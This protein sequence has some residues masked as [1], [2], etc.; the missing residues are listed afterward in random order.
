M[1][2]LAGSPPT[3]DSVVLVP[4]GGTRG[5]ASRRRAPAAERPTLRLV[6]FG[7]LGLYGTIRWGSLLQ[8][9]PVWRLLGLLALS[10]TLVALADRLR[11]YRRPALIALAVAAALVVLPLS[12]IPVR[13]ITHARVTV[14]AN[15]LGDGLSALPRALVPYDGIN[16]WLRMVIVLG[17]GVLLLDG[18]LM[19][20][21]APRPLS[22]LRRAAA[23]LPLMALAAVPSTLVRPSLPYLQGLILFVL[24]AAFMWG[25]RLRGGETMMAVVLASVAGAAGM[26]AAPRLD[27]GTPWLDYQALAGDLAPAHPEAFDWRQ[28]Y[29]PLHW[30][31]TGR[32]VLDVQAQHPDYWKAENLDVF[33]GR[34]WV[35]AS[36]GAPDPQYTVDPA[37]VSRWTQKLHVTLRAM[38]TTN[39]IAAGVAETPQHAPGTLVAGSSQGTWIYPGEL[40]PGYSYTVSS[41]D[42]HPSST[43]L[44]GAGIDYPAVLLPAYLT[45]AIP[46]DPSPPQTGAS[47]SRFR[48]SSPPATIIFAPFG[49]T[50]ATAYGP[51]T[52]QQLGLLRRS[53]YGPV[54]ALSQRLRRG[55]ATP[56][57]YVTRVERYLQRG[58]RY[59]EGPPPSAY[60]LPTFLFKTRAGYCQQFAGAMALLLRMGGIPARV[61]AG[62]TPGSYDSAGHQWVVSD[63]NAHAWVEAWFPRYG[64]VRFDPTP[65]AA[66]ALG[67]H[68]PLPTIKNPGTGSSGPTNP[69]A[70]GLGPTGPAPK[71]AGQGGGG[72]G[73]IPLIIGLVV[74]L[75]VA[76]VAGRM[77]I[78]MREPTDEQLLAELERAL[79]RCGRPIGPRTTL[80]ALEQRF[81]TS[82]EAAGYI[83]ALRL[84]RFAG[85][86][87]PPPETGRRALRAQLRAGLGP[88]GFVRALWALPPQVRV[89][90]LVSKPPPAGIH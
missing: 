64:W 79:R 69:S 89:W 16:G 62:F 33:D 41:Y 50:I 31:R 45:L 15:A 17:A 74:L 23:A 4:A 7:A 75:V 12:G 86:S 13:W 20:A 54:Y 42:P 30:P 34:A 39:V 3:A 37:N 73:E 70:H 55:A 57:D 21:F 40:G 38:K 19:L 58:F 48:A 87:Q 24:V 32:E 83:R 67:G 53:P 72:G 25:E 27:S 49:S 2:A 11:A 1:S 14:T 46:A 44:E 71:T 28:S 22:D 47:Q 81:R 88:A 10:V 52:E 26:I 85:T 78:R 56:Y 18:A 43:E 60:P 84:A 29:G 51:T 61:A 8:P 59:D 36:V 35:D 80:A 68:V 82:A 66:P 63:T 9:A 6:T 90:R 5:A 76:V 65:A 77:T